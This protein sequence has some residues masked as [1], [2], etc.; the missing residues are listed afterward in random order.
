MRKQNENNRIECNNL[1]TKKEVKLKE[2]LEVNH[3]LTNKNELLKQEQH[4]EIIRCETFYNKELGKFYENSRNRMK[5]FGK[6]SLNEVNMLR[7]KSNKLMEGLISTVN[8][9]LST[10]N[11]K[12]ALNTN[13]K[14]NINVED[15]VSKLN[16]TRSRK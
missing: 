5:V 3:Q 8:E 11:S 7:N 14:F 9:N 6:T 1:L 16:E 12:V 2:L 4:G 10:F 15:T 13:E